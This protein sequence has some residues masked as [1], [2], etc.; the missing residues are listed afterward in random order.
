MS[1]TPLQPVRSPRRVRQVLK[2]LHLWLGLSLGLVLAL[3]TL[4]GC[5]LTFEAP[6]LT[7]MH[8]EL[9]GRVVPDNAGLGR[10]LEHI[11][12]TPEGGKLRGIAL[13]NGDLTAFE[14]TAK[15]GDRVYFD[16]TSG[17]VIAHRSG[18]S[19]PMLVLLD[20]HT[21]LLSGD[22]G[23]TI[24]GVVACTGLFM[25]FSGIW[26]YWPGRKRVL[27]HL[28]PHPRPPILRWASW[29]RFAGIVALPLLLIM[30]GTG[31][32]MAYRGAVRTGLAHAFGEPAPAKPPKLQ[33]ASD[34]KVDWSAVL[35]A[36]QAAAPDAAITRISLPAKKDTALVI[37]VR[38][39]G[40]WN[41]AGRS[42]LWLDPFA[43][44]VIGGD[45]ATK[46]GTGGRLANSLFPIHSAAV[47]GPVWH[48]LA[49]LGGLMPSFMLVTGFL[50]WRAR[51]R[52]P[53]ASA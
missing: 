48:T 14:G 11:L 6:L 35:L 41:L 49:V 23:E 13:P 39:P 5:I 46:L 50:F 51:R 43:A 53:A 4:T 10:S 16:P 29:H 42:M 30:I 38:R 25:I 33:D 3:V 24:L 40:E 26:L 52:R 2:T 15:G 22:V 31:T 7:A 1:N 12:A 9:A 44:R 37:R 47:G 27:S 20:W 36:A 28:R 21:H 8:P 19:D 18:R 17:D 34:T 32:T 45:D